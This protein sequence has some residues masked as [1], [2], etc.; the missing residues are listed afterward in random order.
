MKG[1]AIPRGD[2]SRSGCFPHPGESCGT[3]ASHGLPGVD[4]SSL[5]SKP[6]AQDGVELHVVALE[7]LAFFP[8]FFFFFCLLLLLFQ[9][10]FI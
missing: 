10:L 2:P 3:G 7:Q 8:F 6:S 1:G 5:L 9:D 4:P